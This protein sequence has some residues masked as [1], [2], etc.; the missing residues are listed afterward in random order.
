MRALHLNL[1]SRPYRNDRPFYAG[2]AALL[3]L[4]GFLMVK[5]IETAVDYFSATKNTR[6]EIAQLER[7]IA[8]EEKR[9]ADLDAQIKRLDLRRLNTRVAYVN[10]QI[11]TRAFSW[12][13]LLSLLER[14][15][16]SDVRIKSLTPSISKDG[17][18]HLQIE[19]ESK[20]Q[21]GLITLLNRMLLD[22]H[23][24]RPFPTSESLM[25]NG[26]R[27]FS[28]EVDYRPEPQGITEVSR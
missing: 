2:V 5:N 3:L 16:P 24:V 23:F 14:V 8:A 21:Q 10:T 18:T 19:C 28:V 6:A 12:S 13:Q 17:S 4:L 11:A 20:S 27:R 25:E 26:L 22:P 15:V 1:A 9:A 7:Q